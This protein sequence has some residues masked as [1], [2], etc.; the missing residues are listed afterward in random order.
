MAEDTGLPRSTLL[1]VK[2]AT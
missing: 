1:T 2:Q